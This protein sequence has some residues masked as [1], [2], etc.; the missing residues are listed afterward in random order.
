MY[1]RMCVQVSVGYGHVV[2]VTY[3]YTVFSWGEGGRGQLG[4]GD[5]V[6]RASPQL[7]EALKDRPVV[8][9]CIHT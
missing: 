4:H 8:R 2:G 7:I 6:S 1:V 3:D 5:T 9:Y